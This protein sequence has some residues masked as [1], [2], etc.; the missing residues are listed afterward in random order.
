MIIQKWLTFHRST[1]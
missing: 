1:F